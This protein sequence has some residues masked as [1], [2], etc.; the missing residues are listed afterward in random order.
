MNLL[1]DQMRI[2]FD[3]VSIA[4]PSS[5][6][7]SS[8]EAF[9]VCQGF[10]G[11][12]YNN[13]PL[14]GGFGGG[15]A[16][17]LTDPNMVPTDRDRFAVPFLACG[18]L[19]GVDMAGDLGFLDADRSYDVDEGAEGLKPVQAPINLPFA[20]VKEATLNTEPK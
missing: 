15:G 6:R 19:D 8:I 9:V 16:G 10:K 2:L 4:K 5:S 11:G 12:R 1:Y 20:V 18:D 7:N 17:G 3:R 13:L 14:E